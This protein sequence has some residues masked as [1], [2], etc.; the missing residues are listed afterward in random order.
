M[1]GAS[2]LALHKMKMLKA[3]APHLALHHMKMLKAGAPHLAWHHM[4]MLKAGAPHFAL[5]HMKMLKIDAPFLLHRH[6]STGLS[7]VSEG[8]NRW[9]ENIS[10]LKG[11]IP[12]FSNPLMDVCIVA[13]LVKSALNS[14]PI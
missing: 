8:T 10:L 1:A 3:G 12:V 13:A 14:F 5:H 6:S 9:S 2:H 4:K 7:K 11:F